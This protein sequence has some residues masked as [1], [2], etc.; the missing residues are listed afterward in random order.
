[1]RSLSQIELLN[2]DA[3]RKERK[4]KAIKQL[5][6]LGLG[7]R[8]KRLAYLQEVVKTFDLFTDLYDDH[9]LEVAYAVEH[10]NNAIERVA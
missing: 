6:D 10:I 1:M 3:E 4:W 8:A 7:T 9:Y 5:A 2:I